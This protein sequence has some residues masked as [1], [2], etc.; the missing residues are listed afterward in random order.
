MEFIF[1]VL[2]RRISYARG[3]GTS[4][5]GGEADIERSYVVDRS[6]LVSKL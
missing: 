4:W 1:G 5:Y 6:E 2:E 3:R